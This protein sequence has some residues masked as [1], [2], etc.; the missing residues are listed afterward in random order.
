MHFVPER[1]Y[2]FRNVST[3]PFVTIEPGIVLDF[4]QVGAALRPLVQYAT[5]HLSQVLREVLWVLALAVHYL[6]VGD[7]LVLRLERRMP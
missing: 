7:V 3:N 6:I 4:I 5:D 1:P 2:F